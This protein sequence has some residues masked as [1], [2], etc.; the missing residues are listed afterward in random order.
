MPTT[1]V[2]RPAPREGYVPAGT[3]RLFSRDIGQGHPIVVLHGGPEFDHSYFLPELDELA[4]SFRV[5]YYDQRGR[6]RSA[7]GVR[8]DDVTIASEMDD[9]EYVRRHFGLESFAV[10]GH[11]WGGLLAMEYATRHPERVSHLILA[12]SAPASHSDAGLLRASLL[13][14]RPP[15]D[16]ERMGALAASAEYQRGSLDAEA[17]YYRIHFSLT[18]LRPGDL[19]RVLERLRAN[20]TEEGVVTARAIDHRLY[21]ETYRVPGYDLIPGLTAID[22]PTLV[23]HGGHDLVPVEVAEHIAGAIP[24]ARL[25]VLPGCGHFAFLDCTDQVCELVADLVAGG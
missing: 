17:E 8:P 21:D 6:G 2:D 24:G 23:L 15:G 10:L 18:L 25:A 11:S 14:R 5:I 20:F 12:N 3:A 16:I 9:L 22:I 13:S 19:D 1:S 7:Q 4:R